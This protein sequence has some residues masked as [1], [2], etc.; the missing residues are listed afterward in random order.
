MPPIRRSRS[1]VLQRVAMRRLS[2][3]NKDEADQDH[4]EDEDQPESEDT[5]PEIKGLSVLSLIPR[6]I[7]NLASQAIPWYIVC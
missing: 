6:F 3:Q 4:G 5:E 2:Q 1:R 7:T